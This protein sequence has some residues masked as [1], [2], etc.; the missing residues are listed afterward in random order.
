MENTCPSCGSVNREEFDS[1][2]AMLL[3]FSTDTRLPSMFLFVPFACVWIAAA[4]NWSCPKTNY[5]AHYDLRASEAESRV[6]G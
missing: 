5:L 3:Q 4:R 2:I 1:E 6:I